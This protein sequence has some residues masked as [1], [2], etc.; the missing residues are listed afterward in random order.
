VRAYQRFQARLGEALATVF[1]E[2]L[3]RYAGRD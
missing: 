1:D 3:G 2:E